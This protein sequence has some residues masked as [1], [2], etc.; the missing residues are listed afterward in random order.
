MDARR[1]PTL[2]AQWL[3]QQLRDMREGARL[4]LKDTGEYLQRDPSTLSRME[5]GVIPIRIVD[6]L[7]LMN[8]YGV[9]DE[10]L[11]RAIEQLA[12]DVW[13]TGWWEGYADH[14]AGS[15]IDH[16]WLEERAHTIRWFEAL[17]VP[18]LLQT[19]EYAEATIKAADDDA[20]PERIERWVEFRMARQE[21]LD[22]DDP[23]RLEV[24]LDEAVLRR[25]VGGR[26]AMRGQLRH[27]VAAAA[28]PAVELRV[29]PFRAGAHASL[30]GAFTVFRLADP[31]PDIAYT[32]TLAGEV[33]VES[34]GV[35]RFAAAYDRLREAALGPDE[36][37]ALIS[38]AAKT[39]R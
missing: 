14:V 37:T 1:G 7:A 18:G 23:P 38:A 22:H 10:R 20:P 15:F 35:R 25:P 17:V 21:A 29:L 33:Y 28:R 5:A 27:L 36:S 3:G 24:I 31:F 2:R 13:R 6:T 26:R 32:E 12:R 34:D 30:N 8:L 39:L 11:R 4:T 9:H 16:A 19:R